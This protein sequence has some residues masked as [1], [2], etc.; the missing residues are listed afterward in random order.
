MSINIKKKN[1]TIAMAI[2]IGIVVIVVGIFFTRFILTNIKINDT[3]NKL[4]KISAEELQDKIINKLEET[5]ININMNNG[6]KKVITEFIDNYEDTNGFVTA[7]ILY[8]NE[9]NL[10]NGEG[11]AIPVFKIEKDSTGYFKSIKY[12]YNSLNGIIKEAVES[13]FR[14][15]YNVNVLVENND[16]YNEHF[17]T[18]G[19]EEGLEIVRT[20]EDFFKT[21]IMKITNEDIYN[22][23]LSDIE[24]DIMTFGLK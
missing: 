1:I 10:Y 23:Y 12:V 11:V 2:V 8:A 6:K 4:R 13:V 17:R 19:K 14:E 22:N 3:E 7:I 15:E 9:S 20:N 24:Y 21:I 16:R 5:E 18:Y